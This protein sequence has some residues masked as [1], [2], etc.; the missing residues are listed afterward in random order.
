MSARVRDRGNLTWRIC[1]LAHGA[2][3]LRETN[4]ELRE[5]IPKTSRENLTNI[6]FAGLHERAILPEVTGRCAI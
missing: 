1:L 3:N 2:K 6:C 4:V 5:E